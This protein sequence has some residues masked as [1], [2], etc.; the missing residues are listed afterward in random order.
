MRKL[1]VAKIASMK[2]K[3]EKAAAAAAAASAAAAAA[4]GGAVVPEPRYFAKSSFPVMLYTLLEKDIQ[5]IM[6]AKI[7]STLGSR[8]DDTEVHTKFNVHDERLYV[9]TLKNSLGVILQKAYWY[10]SPT[11]EKDNLLSIGQLKERLEE[12][13]MALRRIP[14]EIALATKK[15]DSL[16]EKYDAKTT[17]DDQ[18]LR[19]SSKIAEAQIAIDKLHSEERQRTAEIA[20]YE[21][22]RVL[23]SSA[24]PKAKV[25]S[26]EFDM[27]MS[28][29][30]ML[31]SRNKKSAEFLEEF[32][33]YAETFRKQTVEEKFNKEVASS[34]VTLNFRPT[35]ARR[36][37]SAVP[38]VV[39]APVAAVP[40]PVVAAPA[41]V[42]TAPAPVPAPAAAPAAPAAPAPQRAP[43][44]QQPERK[45][46]S[47]AD[48]VNAL[49][50]K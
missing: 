22:Q 34:G 13:R 39:P 12:A 25:V 15:V 48:R 40:A 27:V 29:I 21:E 33:A 5:R 26:P 30:K 35:P 10:Y 14:C 31:N 42:V 45:K 41:P 49:L 8:D 36:D 32:M 19:L 17:T 37:V 47:K 50:R 4:G 46:V 24:R 16:Q 1:I 11:P 2:K 23:R 44:Q 38:T 9:G 18:R 6:A 3:Q 43:R 28:A 7:R 20:D